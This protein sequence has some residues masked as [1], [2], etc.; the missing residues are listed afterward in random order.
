MSSRS[1]QTKS[2]AL[3]AAKRREARRIEREDALRQDVEQQ[4]TQYF[5]ENAF[6]HQQHPE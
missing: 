6:L 4:L 3:Y 5:Q 2:K 1:N